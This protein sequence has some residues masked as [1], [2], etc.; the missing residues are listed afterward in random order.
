MPKSAK[1]SAA[2]LDKAARRLLE[3]EHRPDAG[4]LVLEQPE[5]VGERPGLEQRRQLGPLRLEGAIDEIRPLE[6]FAEAVP[7]LRFEGSDGDEAAVGRLVDP[8]AGR[9]AGQE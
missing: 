7:E 4:V 2:R 6:Q 3:G 9:T 1:A 8:V 5:P